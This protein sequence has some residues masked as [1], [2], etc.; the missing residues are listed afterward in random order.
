M[1]QAVHYKDGTDNKVRTDHDEKHLMWRWS[2]FGIEQT[3]E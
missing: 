3:V 1:G 2:N